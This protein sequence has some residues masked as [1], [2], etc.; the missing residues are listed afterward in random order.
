M[1]LLDGSRT[2][3]A[4]RYSAVGTWSCICTYVILSSLHLGEGKWGHHPLPSG[5]VESKR[6]LR[7]HAAGE[8][9]NAEGP[10]RKQESDVNFDDFF[11][12]PQR[13]EPGPGGTVGCS[14]RE[15]YEYIKKFVAKKQADM[16]KSSAKLLSKFKAVLAAHEDDKK[17]RQ[18]AITLVTRCLAWYRGT[19]LL[20]DA[21]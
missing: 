18:K 16:T 8:F 10:E 20:G 2:G 5:S 1:C 6:G 12:L 7:R 14:A 21:G 17:S 9:S 11:R 3:A 19:Q 4:A 15:A 13:E